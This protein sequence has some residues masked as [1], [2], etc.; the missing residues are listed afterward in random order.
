MIFRIALVASFLM[1]F[2]CSSS[3]GAA[4]A[5]GPAGPRGPA[6][7][8]GPQAPAGLTGPQGPS[9]PQ[10]QPGT[11]RAWAWVSANG[12]IVNSG[13][14]ATIHVIKPNLTTGVYCLQ[15]TP[16]ILSYYVAM[17]ATRQGTDLS[18]GFINAN[19]GWGSTSNPYG[20]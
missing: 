12:S 5:E 8:A 2:G 14:S 17:L 15:T 9:G 20:G 4:G 7:P 16:N 1:L 3:P 19:N 18:P 13:G 6:G 11:A 10:G